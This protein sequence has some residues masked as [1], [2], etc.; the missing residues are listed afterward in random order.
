MQCQITGHSTVCLTAYGDPLQRNIK[1]R[2]TGP[3]VW[4]IHRWLVNSPH[5]GPVTPKKLPFDYV[6]MNRVLVPAWTLIEDNWC[7]YASVIK[8]SLVQKIIS[9]MVGVKS[10]SEP[11]IADLEL[12]HLEQIPIKFESSYKRF[13]SRKWIWKCRLRNGIH[14]FRTQCKLT[15]SFSE[16]GISWVCFTLA[17]QPGRCF[18]ILTDIKQSGHDR[19]YNIQGWLRSEIPTAS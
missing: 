3:F 16:A 8:P 11:M 18:V 7:I 17:C 1:V 15:Q 9:P 10:L 5:K 12:D 6:I 13:H 4:G 19:A 2:V 14:L